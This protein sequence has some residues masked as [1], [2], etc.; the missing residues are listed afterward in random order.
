[1]YEKKER[2]KNEHPVLSHYCYHSHL[3]GFNV[4]LDHSNARN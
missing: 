1:M 2:K 4:K 3:N